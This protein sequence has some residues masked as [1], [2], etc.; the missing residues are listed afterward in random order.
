MVL[1]KLSSL[2]LAVTNDEDKYLNP[3]EVLRSG[4]ALNNTDQGN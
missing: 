1:W 3:Y 4:V 2:T